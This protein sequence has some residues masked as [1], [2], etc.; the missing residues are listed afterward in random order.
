MHKPGGGGTRV[1]SFPP[2]GERFVWPAA[3]MHGGLRFLEH[4]L[5]AA[6]L[7]LPGD[8]YMLER[9]LRVGLRFAMLDEVVLDYFPSQQWDHGARIKPLPRTKPRVRS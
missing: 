4:E 6:A 1:V 5:V 2:E 8:I 3:L 7:D 9:A